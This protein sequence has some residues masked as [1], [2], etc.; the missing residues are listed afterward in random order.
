MSSLLINNISYKPYN[1]LR[2]PSTYRNYKCT[3]DVIQQ[4]DSLIINLYTDGF[5]RIKAN[6]NMSR[7]IEI[8]KS[9]V[10]IIDK[11]ND[12]AKYTIENYFHINSKYDIS[13]NNGN[14]YFNKNYKFSSNNLIDQ[15]S[16]N[17]QNNLRLNSE[18]YGDNNI[19]N[20]MSSKNNISLSNPIIHEIR[21][22]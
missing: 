20:Y 14:I 15:Y 1:I 7:T 3:S 13:K 19:K 5:N 4:S 6:I 2:Y 8:S 10:R 21:R 18:N 22:L 16:I 11:I 17:Q 9:S 12:V